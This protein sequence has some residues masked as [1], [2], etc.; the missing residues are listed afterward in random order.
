[1][2]R[3]EVLRSGCDSAVGVVAVLEAAA[4]SLKEHGRAVAVESSQGVLV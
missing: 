3:G 4:V 1:V 2:A